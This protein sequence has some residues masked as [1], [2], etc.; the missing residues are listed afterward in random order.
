MY[1]ADNNIK[2]LAIDTGAALWEEATGTV[3]D[4]AYKNGVIYLRS[5][6]VVALNAHNKTI[7]WSTSL[8]V[9]SSSEIASTGDV[10]VVGEGVRVIALDPQSGSRIWTASI[11]GGYN[12]TYFSDAV[13]VVDDSANRVIAVSPKTGELIGYLQLGLPRLITVRHDNMAAGNGQLIIAH[14]NNVYAYVLR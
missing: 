12:F 10:I 4:S 13:Y 11:A 8:A 6:K 2:A 7:L 3:G 5:D 9:S 1:L 14:G